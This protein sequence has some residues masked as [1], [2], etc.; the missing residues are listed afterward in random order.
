MKRLISN[1]RTQKFLFVFYGILILV[2]YNCNIL[3]LGSICII[4]DEFGYWATG[5]A[6]AGIGA[7]WLLIILIIHLGTAF[8]LL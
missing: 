7:R 3:R 2:I 4:G 6:F 5:A 8:G 1:E